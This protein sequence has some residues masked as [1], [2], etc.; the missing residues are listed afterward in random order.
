MDVESWT[1]TTGDWVEG[2][3]SGL[4]ISIIP[5]FV[6]GLAVGIGMKVLRKPI[7]TFGGV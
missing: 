1:K 6:M 4:I 7:E 5:L 2:I 3:T